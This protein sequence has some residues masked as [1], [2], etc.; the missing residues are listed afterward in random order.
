[1]K[2]TLLPSAA[3]AG[4]LLLAACGSSNDSGSKAAHDAMTSS[5][6]GMNA[7]GSA[8]A[9]STPV[10]SPHNAADAEFATDMIPHHAQAVYMAQ[11]AEQNATT[12][13]LKSLAGKV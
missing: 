10:G 11:L 1:M 13:T 9:T 4:A 3:M 5:M 8:A 7:S 2:R 12:S 6:P